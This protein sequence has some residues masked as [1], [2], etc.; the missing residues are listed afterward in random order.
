MRK[1]VEYECEICRSRYFEESAALSCESRGLVDK[2]IVPL[3]VLFEEDGLYRNIIFCVAKFEPPRNQHYCFPSF[4][5]CR[6]TAYG[7]SLGENTCG[8]NH[9]ISKDSHLLTKDNGKVDIKSE[10]FKRMSEFL[11]S[12]N[13]PIRYWNGKEIVEYSENT[14]ENLRCR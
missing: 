14:S 13:I 8:G 6:D 5:A 3:Y 2:N 10:R 12:N 7:D 9:S 1:I 11:K 4:W